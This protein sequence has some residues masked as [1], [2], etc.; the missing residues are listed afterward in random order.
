MPVGSAAVTVRRS[1]D[2]NWMTDSDLK[3]ILLE[4]WREADAAQRAGAPLATII[5]LGSIL[6][7][8]LLHKVESNM[9]K[10][11]AAASAPKE[12]DSSGAVKVKRFSQWTLDNLIIVAHE[13]NWLGKEITDFSIVLRSY[14]NFVHP[15]EQKR[16]R[17]TPNVGICD[18]CWPVVVAALADLARP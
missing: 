1:P 5:L 16:R 4:R 9:A 12:T 8:A 2:L 15:G 7:G 3:G 6:E 18:V 13:V 11:N 14:R 10:A 17:L